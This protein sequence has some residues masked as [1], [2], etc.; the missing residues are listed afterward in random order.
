ML[1]SDLAV[2]YGVGSIRISEQVKR[3]IARFPND[4]MFRLTDD[5][6]NYMVSQMRCYILL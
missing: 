6:V 2:L 4:F 3:N 1:D 5:E